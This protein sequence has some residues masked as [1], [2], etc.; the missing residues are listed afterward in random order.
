MS[1]FIWDEVW[2]SY[3]YG[4]MKLRQQKAKH[5][6]DQL[7]NVVGLAQFFPTTSKA[8]ILEVGCGA[9]TVSNYIAKL[10]GSAV[11]VGLDKSDSAGMRF[12]ETTEEFNGKFLEHDLERPFEL[13]EKYDILLAFGVLEHLSNPKSCLQSLQNHM[14]FES[15]LLLVESNTFSIYCLEQLIGAAIGKWRYGYQQQISKDKSAQR[16]AFH[17]FEVLMS[18]SFPCEERT[19]LGAIDR[20]FWRLTGSGRYVGL[21]AKRAT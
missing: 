17:K 12:I 15:T 4:Q 16:L 18:C 21:V 11:I 8:Q 19:A 2:K 3:P 10:I 9:G 13:S 7:D 14:K 5:K 6:L 20:F 1:F